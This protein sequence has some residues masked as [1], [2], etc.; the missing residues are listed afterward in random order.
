MVGVKRISQSLDLG[1]SGAQSVV[2]TPGCWSKRQIEHPQ[3]RGRF[4][5]TITSYM[6]SV[7]GHM[8]QTWIGPRTTSVEDQA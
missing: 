4:N 2:A 6:C 8:D 5:D 7:G 3:A 1:N